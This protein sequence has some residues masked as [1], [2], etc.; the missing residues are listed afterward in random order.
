MYKYYVYGHYTDDG[1]LFYIG[2]GTGDRAYM[3]G[4]NSV[5]DRI[6]K[7]YGCNVKI[8]LDCMNEEEALFIENE[9]MRNAYERKIMLT[10]ADYVDLDEK[11]TDKE[12]FD[13]VNSIII[14]KTFL[15]N[16]NFSIVELEGQDNFNRR[17]DMF[18][19]LAKNN[20]LVALAEL[21]PY[22]LEDNVNAL[23][24]EQAKIIY[25]LGNISILYNCVDIKIPFDKIYDITKID[26]SDNQEY[27]NSIKEF[28]KQSL[29]CKK[30]NF[31]VEEPVIRSYY[32]S[33]ESTDQKFVWIDFLSGVNTIDSISTL[34]IY[35]NK[36]FDHFSKKSK[37]LH[38][39]FI[40][41]YDKIHC[42]DY[43]ISYFDKDNR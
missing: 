19:N 18:K 31:Y 41:I 8:L 33:S 24:V 39:E 14:R 21:R 42:H 1:E 22:E 30:K 43:I 28:D 20:Y 5:H 26:L 37:A 34:E 12:L 11:P 6:A 9:F 40:D 36:I 4:R 7:M 3:N 35:L 17:N 38:K 10:N 27:Q 15:L 2:K 25:A 16:A 13:F 32:I 23:T 29:Y